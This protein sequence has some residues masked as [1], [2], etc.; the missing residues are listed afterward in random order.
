MFDARY[1]IRFQEDKGKPQ[2]TVRDFLAGWVHVVEGEKEIGERIESDALTQAD[3]F[4]VNDYCKHA[5]NFKWRIF[6]ISHA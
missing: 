6:D 2:Q 4:W 5:Y 3:L 1:K